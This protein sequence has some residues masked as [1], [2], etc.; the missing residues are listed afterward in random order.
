MTTILKYLPPLQ[1]TH[2]QVRKKIL[3]WFS[4][5]PNWQKEIV[6]SELT[7]RCQIEQLQSLT[8]SIEPLLHQI[9]TI[10]KL[11]YHKK[12]KKETTDKTAIFNKFCQDF[13]KSIL[14]DTLQY[15]GKEEKTSDTESKNIDKV[16]FIKK[17]KTLQWTYKNRKSFESFP[18][19][20]KDFLPER[21]KR[22]SW[23]A[24]KLF[25]KSLTENTLDFQPK[26]IAAQ[27]LYKPSKFWS[28]NSKERLIKADEKKLHKHFKEQVEQIRL[29]M[30]TWSQSEL[31]SLLVDLLKVCCKNELILFMRCLME[32]FREKI[33]IDWL[34]DD[35]LLNIFKYLDTDDLRNCSL[36]CRR[37]KLL[38]E[39][40]KGL[41][42]EVRE[43]SFSKLWGNVYQLSGAKVRI[44]EKP[45]SRRKTARSDTV[46]IGGLSKPQSRMSRASSKF[47]SG[48]ENEDLSWEERE[49]LKDVQCKPLRTWHKKEKESEDDS[50]LDIH[51]HLMQSKNLAQNS[52]SVT[53][54]L[55]LEEVIGKLPNVDKAY[56]LQGHMDSVNCV[57]ID[58]KRILT[59]SADRSI[60]MWDSRQMKPFYKLYGHK[61][62]VRCIV[63]D[64]EEIFT[65]SWDASIMIWHGINLTLLKILTGHT[66]VV[67]T[68]SSN[69]KLLISGSHD[70]TVRIWERASDFECIKVLP[71]H[72]SHINALFFDKTKLIVTA[73]TDK[74]LKL[75]NIHSGQVIKVFEHKL[76]DSLTSLKVINY[77]ALCGDVKGKV[78]AFN[79]C[80]GRLEA[81]IKAHSSQ[82]TAIDYLKG[83][84]TRSFFYTASSD[85]CVKEYSLATLTCTRVLHGHRAGLKD[86]KIKSG[87]M[88]TASDDGT[89]R[90]WFINI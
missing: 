90:V 83:T 42:K 76:V 15:F 51:L 53:Q 35:I 89:L 73:S 63:T 7:T 30:N 38:S 40:N 22:G 66:G 86:L 39:Q 33:D 11:T 36:V 84:G 80:N 20:S 14:K 43:D 10:P 57:E 9:E 29:W 62:G 55:K 27:S 67:S 41:W 58:K 56:K 78:A 37:W 23:K 64:G 6:L 82:I 4:I 52:G 32:R 87:K 79:I 28:N 44:I 45:K 71:L 46:S 81:L 61:G 75:T 60:R 3:E 5:W 31:L 74:T 13:S 68:M 19:P 17:S 85:G 88:V 48:G 25:V 77:L 54:V 34:P 2:E 72:Q 47:R 70:G 26:L 50:A 24:E 49:D 21:S 1:L 16:D 65:G 18:S 8:T 12:E 59:G 69:G